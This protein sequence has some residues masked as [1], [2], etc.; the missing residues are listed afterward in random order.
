MPYRR[1]GIRPQTG[2]RESLRSSATPATDDR[3]PVAKRVWDWLTSEGWKISESQFYQHVAM[4]K[5][6][7]EADGTFSRQAVGT[8][9]RENL[10][11]GTDA[12]PLAPL[13][14]VSVLN[15]AQCGRWLYPIIGQRLAP[16]CPRCDRSEFR[17]VF[18]EGW[19]SGRKVQCPSCRETWSWKRSTVF[20]GSE[21]ALPEATLLCLGVASGIRAE[22]LAA[23]L[24]CHR[25]TVRLWQDRLLEVLGLG[26]QFLLAGAEAPAREVANCPAEAPV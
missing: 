3:F 17:R 25:R 14:V 23:W 18:L 16:T 15:P 8:Y 11:G 19:R 5:L 10:T 2:K 22:V 6:K 1:I 21:W 24:G 20:S 26:G 4:G 9:A 7:P 12:L 13:Q